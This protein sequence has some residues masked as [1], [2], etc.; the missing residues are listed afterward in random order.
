ML[1]L[2]H[3]F[4]LHFYIFTLY[5][6]LLFNVTF[7]LFSL[8]SGTQDLHPQVIAEAVTEI[9]QTFTADVNRLYLPTAPDR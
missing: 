4:R 6:I 2:H 8:C 9:I 5:F 1:F 7:S 3:I